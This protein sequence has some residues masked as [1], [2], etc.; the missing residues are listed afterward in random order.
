MT[1]LELINHLSKNTFMETLGIQ[2]IERGKKILL[3]RMPIHSGVHQ[4]MGYLHGGATVA[5]AES[6]GSMLSLLYIN[7][8]KQ[9]AMGLEISANHIRS[10]KEGT[11]FAKA[12]MIHCG[13]ST[14]VIKINVHDENQLLISFCKMT[15]IILLKN[16][17]H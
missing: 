2:F 7:R 3:A 15:N 6:A 12:E 4:P 5:L 13:K 8:D 1:E 17:T 14:H 11:L 9:C 16:T 10:K